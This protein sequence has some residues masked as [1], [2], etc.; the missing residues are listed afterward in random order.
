MDNLEPFLNH[1][2]QRF[3][4]PVQGALDI[5]ALQNATAHSTKPA[6]AAIL[7]PGEGFTQFCTYL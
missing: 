1:K 7:E 2:V 5:T 6:F 4:S 3:A